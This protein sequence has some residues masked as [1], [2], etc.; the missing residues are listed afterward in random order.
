MVAKDGAVICHHRT[1]TRGLVVN[2][3]HIAESLTAR[4]RTLPDWDGGL[5]RSM[6]HFISEGKDGVWDGTKIS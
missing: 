3:D 1:S 5:N 6:Q 2:I 4:I